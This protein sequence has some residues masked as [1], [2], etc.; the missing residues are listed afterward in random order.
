MN[1][2][3]AQQEAQAGSIVATVSHQLSALEKRD[4]ELW[5][6]ITGTSILIGAGL[7]A[8]IFPSAIIRQGNF[9]V[10]LDIPRELFIGLVALLTLLN[11][12]VISRRIE[13]RRTREAL[14]STSIQSEIV[15]LQSFIDPLTEVYNRRTLDEMFRRYVNRA[16]RLG[17]PLTLMVIDVDRFKEINTVFGHLTGDF[18]L[19][20]ISA[21]FRG[22]V[23]GADAVVRY[24]GDEFLVILADCCAVAAEIVSSRINKSVE[25][26]NADGHLKDLKLTLSIGIAEWKE[27]RSLD[28][29]LDEADR[30]MYSSKESRKNGARAINLGPSAPA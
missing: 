30:D 10:E 15:R 9:H 3:P 4:W 14:I 21:I 18:V 2:P 24:G 20:D 23:R 1:K 26:W 17:K 12:Y 27:S 13:L 5:L 7:L 11:T 19:A 8:L 6:T 29:I 16:Q 22:A 25:D 28:A